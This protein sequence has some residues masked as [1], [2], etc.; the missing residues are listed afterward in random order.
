MKVLFVL[1]E[2]TTIA[3][4]FG[5][6]AAGDNETALACLEKHREKLPGQFH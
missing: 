5:A 1:R 6:I 3:D 4:Y 2:E